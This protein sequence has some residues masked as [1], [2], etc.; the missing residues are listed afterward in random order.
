M[1]RPCL[2]ARWLL[3]GLT[4]ATAAAS[5][6]PPS[7]P[8][9]AAGTVDRAT[10]VEL[11]TAGR[12][13]EAEAGARQ[14][15]S[16]AEHAAAPDSLAI[17]DALDAL[18]ES[19]WRGGKSAEP[20]SKPLALRAI[21]IREQFQGPHAADLATSINSLGN[22]CRLTAEY[23]QARRLFERALAI[24]EQT[25][26]FDHVRTA[27]AANNLG[28]VLL[29]QGELETAAALFQ[30]AGDSFQRALGPEHPNVAQCLG[31][32]AIVKRELGEYTEARDLNE[33]AL[34]IRERALGPEHPAVA[35]TLNNLANVYRSLGDYPRSRSLLER[36]LT[37][38]ERTLGA[39]HP[40][41]ANGLN[42]LATVLEEMGDLASARP[43]HQRALALRESVLGAEHPDHAQ[44]LANLAILDWKS[45]DVA[46]AIP[47]YERAVAITERAVGP[48]NAQVG[49]MLPYLA[50]MLRE[51]GR[52]AEARPLLDR[53]LELARTG[54]GPA[55]PSVAQC[56]RDLSL[57]LVAMGDRSAALAAAL[58]A[59]SVGRTH[60]RL[61]TRG[62]TEAQALRYAAARSEGLD[63]ALTLVAG[64]L[65][66]KERR[67]VW[68]AQVQS[69]A[70]VLDE[71]AARHRG[72]LA[73]ND[74]LIDSLHAQLQLARTRLANLSVRGVGEQDPVQYH[75][76]LQAATDSSQQ[77][78]RALA[79]RS[80]TFAAEQ[81]RQRVGLDDVLAALPQGG[82]LVAYCRYTPPA[83]TGPAAPGPQV[84]A[85]LAFVAQPGVASVRAVPLGSAKEIEAAVASWQREAGRVL[86]RID[87]D[88][89]ERAYFDAGDELRR[90]VWDPVAPYLERAETVF[91]V[92]DGALHLV[93]FAAL[94]TRPD[95][96]L[97]ETRWLHLLSAER[98]LV[99]PASTANRGLLVVGDPDYDRAGRSGL[100]KLI[101]TV[102]RLRGTGAPCAAL[103]D[104][105]FDRLPGTRAE[106]RDVAGL[107][108]RG[109]RGEGLVNLR[110]TD[111]DEGSVKAQMP[112]KRIVHLATHGFFLGGACATS[113]PPAAPDRRVDSLAGAVR[114]PAASAENPLLLSGLALAGAN[115][116]A[117][118]DPDTEDG[119][120][121]AEEVAALDLRGVEW[122]V[123][124]ACETAAGDVLA[125]E[126][127]FGLRRAFQ[128]AGAGTLIMSLWAVEDEAGRAWMTEL[129]RARLQDGLDTASAVRRA[130]LRVL[131][132]RRKQGQ[133]T[134]PSTW[135]GFIAAGGWR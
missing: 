60:L 14:L 85:Y 107:F 62:L 106:S 15:L 111:A 114:L 16:A 95:G 9:A 38:E 70:V 82:A 56:A 2:L 28:N 58:Q 67:E 105:R 86:W 29:D 33:R 18:C 91:L 31:N 52:P 121:T 49:Q 65:S 59:E 134:H 81:A 99:E 46:A 100:S 21:R 10:V 69:R 117:G 125:G 3:L 83:G 71:M 68:D 97:V 19:L 109:R 36:A 93:H 25:L 76:L 127:V 130:N 61:T 37:I 50:A 108:R 6:A 110:G 102:A 40:E 75:A 41:V 5:Q 96:F 8:L 120:L 23:A 79:R 135:G 78:E 13:A 115:R 34:S 55:H 90:R 12:Y 64:G 112:G 132:Q 44:S 66:P 7:T 126:G 116:R 89:A 94:P 54:L 42:S 20:T 124:S 104:L 129:Y 98:D 73:A 92:P 131:Q 74:P 119:V 39:E 35:Q 128:T 11:L 113:S 17:A 1:P 77:A 118:A 122:A 80:R 32:L 30:R 63:L 24:R 133:T 51:A 27:G 48:N 72:A 84:P 88:A 26:G 123:L 43:L 101:E 4:S 57:T 47:R 45:G 87:P 103:D 22:M 53:A